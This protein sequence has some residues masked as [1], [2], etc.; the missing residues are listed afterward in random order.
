MNI[1]IIIPTYNSEN[2]IYKCLTSIKKQN[3][4]KKE[5]LIIDGGSKD[6]TI[7]IAKKFDCK[8]FKNKLRTGEAGKA[9]GLL[10]S[11]YKN[12]LFLDSD[13]EFPNNDCIKNILL[14]FKEKNIISAE[15]IR[16]CYKKYG[17]YR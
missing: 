11:K 10:K 6:N 4:I 8:I 5:I 3:I 14:P 2:Y 15:P 13:N 7:K 9:L 12:I 1:S 17:S 16:F